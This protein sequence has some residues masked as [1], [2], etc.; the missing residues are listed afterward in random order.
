MT[1]LEV[2]TI[3]HKVWEFGNEIYE[4]YNDSKPQEG[5]NLGDSSY[6]EPIPRW[7]YF[8]KEEFRCP[9]CNQ[10]RISENLIDR[11]DFSR[12]ISGLQM[13][14]S[15]GYR[16]KQ[17]NR[18]VRGKSKSSHLYGLGA[19]IVCPSGSLKATMVASFFES[20]I[21]RIGIYK[22]FIHVD[23]SENLPS[24]MLWVS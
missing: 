12:S 23:I 14:V 15:S 8:K 17:H 4:K 6:S 13:R 10:N 22:N 2:L 1:P 21:K 16:C 20:G 18:K 19:D 3:G 5:N 24:P 7:K 9:C 11:L